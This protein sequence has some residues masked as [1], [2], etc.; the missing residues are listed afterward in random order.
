MISNIKSKYVLKKVFSFV[1]Q[2]KYLKV[3]NYNK[4]IQQKADIS[5]DTYK[6]Y[7]NQIEIEIIPKKVED[8]KY[9]KFINIKDF[10]NNKV[11]FNYDSKEIKRNY[12]TE[13]DGTSRIIVTIDITD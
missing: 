13:K 12:F 11:Y 1:E 4:Q 9:T 10:D 7:F 2:H 3:I 6:L 8:L 5:L